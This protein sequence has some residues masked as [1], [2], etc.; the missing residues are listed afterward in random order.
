MLVL[1]GA[2]SGKSVTAERMLGGEEHVD[3]VAT[4]AVPDDADPEWAARVNTHRKRRPAGWTT[5]ETRELE[6]VLSASAPIR[7]S[8]PVLVDCLSTWL[9]GVMDDLG[10]WEKQP[11]ADKELAARVDGLVDAW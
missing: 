4:G 10:V 8:T 3:Y 2:R 7:L 9:A 5:L 1:G 11:G 6:P